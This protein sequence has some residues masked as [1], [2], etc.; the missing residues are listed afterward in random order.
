MVLNDVENPQVPKNWQKVE[1]DPH[2]SVGM[3]PVMFLPGSMLPVAMTYAPVLEVLNH[4]IQ[5]VLKDLELYADD[6][7]PP[8]YSLDLELEAIQ[9]TADARRWP[10]FH[11]VGYSAGG[12]IALAF[13]ARYPERVR[14]LALVE[15]AWIGNQPWSEADAADWAELKQVNDL[16][17]AQRLDAFL[18][19]QL[20]PGLE[21]PP[22]SVASKGSSGWIEKRPAGI[23]AFLR[24]LDRASLER[25][26]FRDYHQPVLYCV[27]TGSRGY[28]R[29]NADAL[30][31]YFPN[32]RMEVY[33]G[34][35]H[36]NPPQ[37]YDPER[38]ARELTEL[39]IRGDAALAT[40]G[41]GI[42]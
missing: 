25:V 11:L 14:S 30:N 3:L 22:L 12:A 9:T 18:R 29:R 37:R 38:F 34:A 21:P 26:K 1:S 32:F 8:D 16:P 19:W 31:E 5:P 33:A 36:L 27:G 42:A 7:P 40:N 24:A 2:S 35:N 39:W 10:T 6:S 28:F 13:V 15:P 4:Q 41:E 20:A 17:E 23:L